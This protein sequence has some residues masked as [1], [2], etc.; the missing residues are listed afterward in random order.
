MATRIHLHKSHQMAQRHT[1]ALTHSHEH[2]L[3]IK[4]KTGHAQRTSDLP[5]G[6]TIHTEK[7]LNIT[8]NGASEIASLPV[9]QS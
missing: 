3:Q 7:D 1:H 9:Q 6:Q 5:I 4:S 2:S 8:G